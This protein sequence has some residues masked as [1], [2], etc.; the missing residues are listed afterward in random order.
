MMKKFNRRCRMLGGALVAT[1]CSS[2]ALQARA[3]TSTAEQSLTIADVPPA[4]QQ[5]VAGRCGG[6]HAVPPPSSIPKASWKN[7]VEEMALL[8]AQ[9][10]LPL[11]QQEASQIFAFYQALAPES[12]PP[13]EGKF[14]DSGLNFTRQ[15]VGMPPQRDRP[16]VTHVEVTDL[17]GNGTDDVVVSDNDNSQVSWLRVG[18]D[19]EW[20]ETVLAKIDAPVHSESFDADGDGDLDIV[21]ASMG[22]MHPNDNLTGAAVL[23]E[24]DGEQNFSK[25]VLVSGTPRISD[26]QPADF[27]GDGDLDYLLAMFGWRTTGGL[28]WLETRAGGLPPFLHPITTIN[29]AMLVEPLDF[30]ADGMLDFVALITQQHETLVAFRNR[31]VGFL[32]EPIYRAPHP[33]YGTSGFEMVDLDGDSDI[34]ILLSNG[35]YMDTDS[36][37]KSYHGVRWLENQGDFQFASRELVSLPG[38]YRAIARDLDG[39]GDLDVVASS[40]FYGWKK[41]EIPSLVW[42][43]NDGQQN[44]TAR[45]IDHQPTNLATVD[46]GDFNGDG[47]S[48]IISGGMH[49]GGPLGRVGRLTVWMAGESAADGD[50]RASAAVK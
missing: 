43:E 17:D 12:M 36:S 41:T 47:R 18:A 33:A 11:T 28:A 14:A 44:F 5:L 42:L 25:T 27:D 38:C 32:P 48:D 49:V 35:D 31:G 46:V 10:N 15:S 26:V 29:G 22:Y 45:G 9:A 34:D 50:G 2:A 3:Q 20:L 19:G 24:N 16:T 6:C 4:V 39:D 40:L 8:M 23:L 21:V 37:T 13:F 7:I 30:D 1:A